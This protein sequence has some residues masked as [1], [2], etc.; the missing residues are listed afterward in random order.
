LMHAFRKSD[1]LGQTDGLAAIAGEYRGTCHGT[2]LCMY[3]QMGYT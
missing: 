1:G 2:T 3:I